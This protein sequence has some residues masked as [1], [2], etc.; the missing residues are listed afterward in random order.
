[1]QLLYDVGRNF[2]H[3]K[4]NNQFCLVKLSKNLP[5]SSNAR[6][7]SRAIFGFLTY[8][9]APEQR[10]SLEKTCVFICGCWFDLWFS[11]H[12]FDPLAYNN[13]RKAVAF[14]QKLCKQLS[15][16]GVKTILPLIQKEVIGVPKEQLR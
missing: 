3:Y 9:L 5:N 11:S 1:M 13:L 7:N 16:S 14:F 8:I 6:W 12:L 15:H 2:R 4:Q 10:V